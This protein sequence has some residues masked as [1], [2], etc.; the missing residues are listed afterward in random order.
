M[1]C[2]AVAQV[3]RIKMDNAFLARRVEEL[4]ANRV[5]LLRQLRVNAQQ[6]GTDALRFFGL[7]GEQMTLVNE[8]AENLRDGRGAYHAEMRDSAHHTDRSYCAQSSCP[9]ETRVSHCVANSTLQGP[10]GPPSVRDWR[11]RSWAPPRRL[12]KRAEDSSKRTIDFGKQ[13]CARPKLPLKSRA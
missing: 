6:V 3:D 1:L 9:S 10:T 5:E 8:F 12:G 7:T 11:P 4:E 2:N 13:S